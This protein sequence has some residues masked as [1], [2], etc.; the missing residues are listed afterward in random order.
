M[1]YA[2]ISSGLD[3]LDASIGGLYSNR[4]YLMRGPSQS[5]RTT[6]SLQFLI[7]GLENGENGLMISNDRIE[8]VILK[9]EAMGISLE[10]Y[11]MENR[12]ILMEYPQEILKGQF[13]FGGI[14]HLLGEIEHYVKMYN[15][16]RL[17]VDTLLPLLIKPNESHFVNYVFS[18]MNS[19]DEMQVTTM[20]T[21]GEPSSPTALRIVQ[22]LEDA[23]VGSFALGKTAQ[24]K[25][26]QRM[27]SVHKLVNQ[28]N[29]P[30]QFRV[31]IDYGV[32][33]VQD[34]PAPNS[35]QHALAPALGRKVS[36]KE[37]PLHVVLVDNDE[38]TESQIEEI[39]HDNSKTYI[40]TTEEEIALQLYNL[41]ADLLLLSADQPGL[42]WRQLLGL[43]RDAYPK[44]PIFI[45]LNNRNS[46]V[47]YQKVRQAGAD[48]MFV[49]PLVPNDLL[50]AFEKVLRK[51]GTYDELI[52]RRGE[53]IHLHDLPEDFSDL[54][55][56]VPDVSMN[57]NA[58]ANLINISEFREKLVAQIWK[59]T[60]GRGEVALVS[61]KTVY[62]GQAGSQPNM[63]QGLE[64]IKS[65]AISVTN[66]L[67]GLNDYACRYMDKIVVMLEEGSRDGAQAFA[68]RVTNELRTDL[69]SRLNLQLN[70]HFHIL[71]AV[72]V[73][74]E[75]GDNVNDL[76]S[77][78]TDVSRNFVKSIN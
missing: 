10:H 6:A 37:L 30:T 53:P 47:N 41:D 70:K 57:M 75:D 13:H 54:S 68:R 23:V 14:V 77:Q 46:K 78:V 26:E 60:Q 18:L 61:F 45:L 25:S 50:K 43:L 40:Y 9:A 38:D 64:L 3:F 16:S 15:C 58:E 32:G 5:G 69:V 27:L 19:F 11:L 63:P 55:Q 35:T 21:T 12:L 4:C 76:L 72:A 24:L 1:L 48:G 34:I 42:N 20:V 52:E 66:S 2:R 22:L 8:N 49:K 7:A 44:L 74:P 73:Y 39:F 36:L 62:I 56:G 65:V 67:R 31:R 28:I 33:I 51:S 17:A 29:P 71:T 59:G